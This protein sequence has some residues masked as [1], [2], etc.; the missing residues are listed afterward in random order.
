MRVCVIDLVTKGGEK[1]DYKIIRRPQFTVVGKSKSFDFD[2]FV[3][4][5]SKFWKEYVG[6]NDYQKLYCLSDGRPGPMTDAPLLSAYF[7]K[8][9]GKRDEFVEFVE[10]LGILGN[11][12]NGC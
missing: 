4:N 9:D 5:G 10:F 8:E 1:M 12:R 7:P 3:K 2:G 11:N 6:S